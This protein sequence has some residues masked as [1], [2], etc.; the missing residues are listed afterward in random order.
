[1][2]ASVEKSGLAVFS[3]IF[4]PKGWKA[5][6]DGQETPILRVNYLLRGLVL[7]EGEHTV[8]MRF[9]P[10]AYY[11]WEMVAVIVQYL[12]VLSILFA[13]YKNMNSKR[14]LTDQND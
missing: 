10:S 6:V 7:P 13:V 9:E 14:D 3:E 11:N 5:F 1:Y 8:E 2:K 12:V 4:Y